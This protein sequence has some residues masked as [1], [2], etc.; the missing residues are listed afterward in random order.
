MA[1]SL[2]ERY[3]ARKLKHLKEQL[4]VVDDQLLKE[5]R[6]ANLITEALDQEDLDKVSAIIQKLDAIKNA[7]GDDMKTLVNGIE[8]AQ[9]EIN[10]YTA[11]G[12]LTK[13]WTKLK[14]IFGIDNPVVKIATF[15]SA[16][17][18][19]FKQLPQILKNNGI[20]EDD[21]KKDLNDD[22]QL[23]L[24]DAII[25]QYAKKPDAITNALKKTIPNKNENINQDANDTNSNNNANKGPPT[26]DP[27][28]L[29]KASENPKVAAKIKTIIAQLQKALSPGGIFGAFKKIP[30]VDSSAMAQDLL[31][32]HVSRL[33]AI[34]KAVTTGPQSSEV[35]SGLKDK[36]TGVGKT[37]TEKTGESKPTGQKPQT[38]PNE[39]RSGGTDVNNRKLEDEHVKELSRFVAKQTNVDPETVHKILVVLNNNQKL[40]A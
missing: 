38:E 39:K 35:A 29:A 3:E 19:G 12:P 22:N 40:R 9:A 16:L 27:T 21:L 32:A 6:I 11:G 1:Q 4:I 23:T 20:S 24:R 2:K 10:K 15:A 28:E 13:A 36:I 8:Q 14:N 7:A 5:N 25:K 18:K 31:N 17:E 33:V 34:S 26:I 30:Y 37:E